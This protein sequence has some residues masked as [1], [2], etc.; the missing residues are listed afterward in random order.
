MGAFG[1]S[2]LIYKSCSNGILIL[3]VARRNNANEWG[4]PGGKVDP[5]ETEKAAA[6]RECREET[7]LIISDLREV[8]RRDIGP[9]EAVTFMCNWIGEPMMQEGEPEC[10]WLIPEE[11]MHGIFGQYNTNLF[12]KLN[13]IK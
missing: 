9:K 5:G 6:I 7:G 8:N 12:K 4:M 11:L 2:I 10:R 3:G 13:L 1:V